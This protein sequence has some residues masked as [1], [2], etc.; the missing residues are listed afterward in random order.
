MPVHASQSGPLSTKINMSFPIGSAIVKTSGSAFFFFLLI[1]HQHLVP[2]AEFHVL[3]KEDR[4][5]KYC[6][7][8]SGVIESKNGPYKNP[9][10][11]RHLADF[12]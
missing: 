2:T 5:F 7:I 3:L 10:R 8:P 1:S 6:E 9:F 12:N 11:I 4:R